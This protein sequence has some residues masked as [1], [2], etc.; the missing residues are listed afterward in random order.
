MSTRS[1]GLMCAAL[2]LTACGGGRRQ[3]AQEPS[4]RFTVQI[5]TASFPAVQR[6][7]ERTHLV[8]A[9]HNLSGKTL[10]D[11]AVSV[12]NVTCAFPAPAGQGTS[13][14]AFSEHLQM[15]GLARPSRPVWVL[16]NPP[17]GSSGS[18]AGSPGGAV[19]AYSNTWALGPLPAGRTA[20]FDF[21]VTA[22][23]P[24]HHVVAWEVAAGLNGKAKAVLPDGSLAHGTFAVTIHT[25]PAR[26]YVNNNGQVITT[27]SN[28]PH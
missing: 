22:V 10:P 3:D 12:C 20:T 25:P 14:A 8:L 24:G 4:G 26:T 19:T 5:T 27:S 28:T 6:L 2:L 11:V 21:G 9:V 15:A 18:G 17:D 23:K 16:D 13:A 7:S 1:I